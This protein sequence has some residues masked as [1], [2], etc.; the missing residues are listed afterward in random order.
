MNFLF[1]FLII[2][3]YHKQYF[4]LLRYSITRRL[5]EVGFRL[6]VLVRL[7]PDLGKEA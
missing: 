4:L 3:A 6:L 5:Q 1:G 7:R 2:L